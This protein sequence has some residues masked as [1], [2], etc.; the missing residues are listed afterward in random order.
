MARKRKLMAQLELCGLDKEANR[1]MT[2]KS[3][4]ALVADQCQK[5]CD[6]LLRQVE[7]QQELSRL[8]DEEETLH[9]E[10]SK[11]LADAQDLEGK[12]MAKELL[13]RLRTE[14]QA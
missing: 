3:S 11:R 8:M 6:Q 4:S 2:E 10:I 12:L 9:S 13:M 14:A 5:L 7:L 1:L